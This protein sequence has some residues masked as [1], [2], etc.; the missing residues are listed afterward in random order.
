M[1]SGSSTPR[2]NLRLSVET[3]TRACRWR[4]CAAQVAATRI[5]ILPETRSVAFGSWHAPK[6]IS[7]AWNGTRWILAGR[8]ST[9]RSQVEFAVLLIQHGRLSTLEAD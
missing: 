2:K 8:G 4:S 5:R 6:R 3:A 1:D 9:G 7:D